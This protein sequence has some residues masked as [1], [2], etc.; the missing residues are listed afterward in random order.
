MLS[1]INHNGGLLCL[2]FS[3]GKE[4][5]HSSE[6]CPLVWGRWDVARSHAGKNSDEQF[7]Y[8]CTEKGRGILADSSFFSNFALSCIDLIETL[9]DGHYP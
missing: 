2:L 5:G 9:K 1:I 8:G 4:G 3:W 6:K 7:A